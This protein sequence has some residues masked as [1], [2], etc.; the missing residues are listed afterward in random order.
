MFFSNFCK[1][2]RKTILGKFCPCKTI[3][4][5]KVWKGPELNTTPIRENSQYRHFGH[6]LDGKLPINHKLKLLRG[7]L[8]DC[9]RGGGGNQHIPSLGSFGYASPGPVEA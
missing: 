5:K 8:G 2:L 3:H 9:M 4:F 6:L 1:P 7:R